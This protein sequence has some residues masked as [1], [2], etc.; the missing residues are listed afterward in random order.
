MPETIRTE[1]NLIKLEISGPQFL[2]HKASLSST[3]EILQGYR[4]GLQFALDF[5]AKTRPHTDEIS[6]APTIIIHS[7]EANSFDVN[8]IIDVAVAMSPITSLVPDVN[9]VVGLGWQLYQKATELISFATDYFNRNGS[10]PT[11]NIT[12]S[13]NASP[14][15][16]VAGGNITVTPDVLQVARGIHGDTAKIASQVTK[17]HADQVMISGPTTA[18]TEAIVVHGAN[19]HNFKVPHAEK[20][21]AQPVEIQCGLYSLNKNTLNGKLE[22]I[23]EEEKRSLPFT[24][25]E[26]QEIGKYVDGL[27]AVSSVVTAIREMSV[28]ALGETRIKKLHLY[29]IENRWQ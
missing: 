20:R 26:G 28:N 2:P 5:A 12:N 19:Q 16:F 6:Y 8:T 7:T 22:I 29:D 24:I 27:K 11:M 23:E 13:P 3:L 10:S 21:D 14:I 17:G 1:E 4:N 15:F 9:S 25:E 18:N